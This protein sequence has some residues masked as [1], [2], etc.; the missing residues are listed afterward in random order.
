MRIKLLKRLAGPDGVFGP[1]TYIDLPAEVAGP[2]ITGGY[3]EPADAA[4]VPETTTATPDAEKAVRPRPNLRK[5]G[6]K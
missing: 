4:P 6:G 2:L 1:G 3:A 5:R